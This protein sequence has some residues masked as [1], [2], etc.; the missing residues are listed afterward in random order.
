MCFAEHSIYLPSKEC[1]PFVKKYAEAAKGRLRFW[2]EY[3][4]KRKSV[5]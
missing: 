3:K 1:K 5:A 4:E 2:E